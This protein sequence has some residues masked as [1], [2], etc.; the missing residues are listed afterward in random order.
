MDYPQSWRVVKTSIASDSALQVVFVAPDDSSITVTEVE[1][2]SDTTDDHK[3]FVTLNN[4][5]IVQVLIKPSEDSN[6]SFFDAAE[7]LI[8][9]IR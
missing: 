4:N 8:A 2:S 3:Q 5:V 7:Q 1:A 6:E 9:S